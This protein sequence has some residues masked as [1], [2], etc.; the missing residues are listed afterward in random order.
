LDD[1]ASSPEE[2]PGTPSDPS[3]DPATER[4]T[5]LASAALAGARDSARPM[6]RRRRRSRPDEPVYSGPAAD[7]RDPTTTGDLLAGLVKARGWDRTLA[8]ARL[9]E[10]W[11]AVVGPELAAH[12]RPMSLRGGELTVSA[13]STAWATQLRLLT[14]SL[15]ARLAAELGPE[16]VAR[17]R[18]VGPAAPSWKHGRLSVRGRGPRDT[19]G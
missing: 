10:D 4:A 16:L 12:S 19:Y 11:A 17:V 6:R 14:S 7:P 5:D 1:V 13:S 18:V 8:E 15:L 9:F 2:T 3:R